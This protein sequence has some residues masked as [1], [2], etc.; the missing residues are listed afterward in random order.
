MIFC[1]MNLGKHFA[2]GLR[3][4]LLLD[5]AQTIV[6]LDL[7]NNYLGDKGAE[8]VA[9]AVKDSLSIVT[10]NLSSNN[11]GNAGMIKVFNELEENISL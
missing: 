10:L 11:I 6:H 8:I 7:N 5:T 4:V 3:D 1:Q 9:K 2:E